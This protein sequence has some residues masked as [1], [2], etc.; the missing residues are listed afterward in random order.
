MAISSCL[1]GTTYDI[2]IQ[3]NHTHKNVLKKEKI[4]VHTKGLIYTIRKYHKLFGNDFL[5]MPCD[6][7]DIPRRRGI[8]ES[9]NSFRNKFYKESKY[10]FFA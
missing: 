6:D 10:N 4:K 3:K 9:K 1:K 5:R 2:Y 8:R 7:E